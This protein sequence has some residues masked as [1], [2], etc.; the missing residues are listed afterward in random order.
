MSTFG[1]LGAHAAPYLKLSLPAK[2]YN[3]P[4][5]APALFSTKNGARAKR[6]LYNPPPAPVVR[7][8][9]DDEVKRMAS[10]LR[11]ELPQI[12]DQ[13]R[14]PTSW[15]DLYYFF[16][17]VDLWVEGAVFLYFVISHISKEN[18]VTQDAQNRMHQNAAIFRYAGTWVAENSDRLAKLS[19]ETDFLALFG[20]AQRDDIRNFGH[21]ELE[22]MKEAIRFHHMRLRD[23]T[24]N[25]SRVPCTEPAYLPMH[26]SAHPMQQFVQPAVP[27]VQ[28]VAPQVYPRLNRDVQYTQSIDASELPECQF[29]MSLTLC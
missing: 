13:I 14:N 26:T 29:E 4:A 5:D 7:S 8:N 21:Y 12:A 11:K 1:P 23:R 2:F 6:Q 17:A 18:V 22:A 15:K 9:F 24:N 27:H 19:P 10:L 28:S 16:D 20:P 3:V 25:L